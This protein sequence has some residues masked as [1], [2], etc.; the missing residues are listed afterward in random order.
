M[1]VCISP[2]GRA[3][4][5]NDH[6]EPAPEWT[7]RRRFRRRLKSHRSYRAS[8]RGSSRWITPS[9][10]TMATRMP[11]GQSERARAPHGYAASAVAAR[12]TTR[13]PAYANIQAPY[14]TTRSREPTVSPELHN[15]SRWT[16]RPRRS[17]STSKPATGRQP[18]ALFGP[19]LAQSARS[20]AAGVASPDAVQSRSYDNG[21]NR[22]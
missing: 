6:A 8:S 3:S 15:E 20:M 22:S 10:T 7:A 17:A 12:L 13:S 1:A 14:P 2:K 19:R 21:T 5:V 4:M 9:R 16:L 18:Q 11:A